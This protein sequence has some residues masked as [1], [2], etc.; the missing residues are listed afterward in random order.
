MGRSSGHGVVA[1]GRRITAAGDHRVIVHIA[2]SLEL[3]GANVGR[4]LGEAL[5]TVKSGWSH[6]VFVDTPHR[7]SYQAWVRKSSNERNK[8][9]KLGCNSDKI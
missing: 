6:L 7:W 2:L 1:D 5:T 9:G 8:S 3:R 4:D